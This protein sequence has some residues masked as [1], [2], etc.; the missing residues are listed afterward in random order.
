MALG[1]R[2]FECA[3]WVA[4]K[5][6]IKWLVHAAGPNAVHV[7]V[8]NGSGTPEECDHI[9]QKVVHSELLVDEA[10]LKVADNSM[11]TVLDCVPDSTTVK[12]S[13]KE[14]AP[15]ITITKPVSITSVLDFTKLKCQ[16][17]LNGNIP[18]KIR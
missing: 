4:G 7:L 9:A 11:Q 3:T 2:C 10:M 13:V 1:A 6:W 16:G 17:E 12:L 14:I 18:Y 15:P 8:M 5:V